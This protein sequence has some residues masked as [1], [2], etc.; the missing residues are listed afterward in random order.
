[1]SSVLVTSPPMTTVASG[2]WT[3]A[4]A[5]WARSIG[6][7]PSAASVAVVTTG[8]SRSSAP[9]RTARDRSSPSPSNFRKAATITI[10]FRTAM[11]KRA[12]KPTPAEIENGSPAR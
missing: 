2:R 9:A 1:M 3:S 6:M 11:P 8:R 5:P 12:M 7:N 10:P 4:P